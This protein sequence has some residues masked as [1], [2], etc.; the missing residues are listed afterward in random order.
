MAPA[1]GG[2]AGC[3]PGAPLTDH[4]L[5]V[6]ARVGGGARDVAHA[7]GQLHWERG[8]TRWSF[9]NRASSR[10]KG[11]R[12]PGMQLAHARALTLSVRH[13]ATQGVHVAFMLRTA[14]NVCVRGWCVSKVF[15]AACGCCL[16]LSSRCMRQQ[17]RP[18]SAQATQLAHD[19]AA[20]CCGNHVALITA[21]REWGP[22]I[23]HC[24]GSTQCTRVQAASDPCIL[25]TASHKVHARLG[26]MLHAASMWHV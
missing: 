21:P 20:R 16:R 3:R 11:G 6:R 8:Q 24:R 5:P 19:S 18:F 22:P 23:P 2:R 15:A 1:L 14:V 7:V 13:E 12:A 4:A 9:H 26:S 25:Q 17:C 10:S